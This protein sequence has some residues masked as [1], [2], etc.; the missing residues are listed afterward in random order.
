MLNKASVMEQVVIRKTTV[1]GNHLN[2]K[3]FADGLR[4]LKKRRILHAIRLVNQ[5][6]T[7]YALKP[8]RQMGPARESQTFIVSYVDACNPWVDAEWL[9]NLKSIN[10]RVYTESCVFRNRCAYKLVV[11]D[12]GVD[13]D[14]ISEFVR[15]ILVEPRSHKVQP[16]GA[17]I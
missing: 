6:H 5:K 2:A 16:Q 10:L 3:T 1:W 7:T 8:A 11:M 14:S 4:L 9:R 15:S 13:V 17:A 12:S